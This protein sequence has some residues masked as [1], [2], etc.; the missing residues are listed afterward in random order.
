M[1]GAYHAYLVL[2]A[3][4]P[5]N[6]RPGRV[7]LLATLIIGQIESAKKRYHSLP[8]ELKSLSLSRSC[9]VASAASA[10][11]AADMPLV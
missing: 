4:E 5:I 9:S 3:P 6:E 2:S 10:R 1:S 11:N 7:F 8:G